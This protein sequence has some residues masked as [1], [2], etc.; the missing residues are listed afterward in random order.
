MAGLAAGDVPKLKLAW[1]FGIPGSLRAY[2]QPTVAGGRVFIG[3]G[4]RKIF[5]LDAARAA[6][7]GCLTR[8]T[9]VR[10]A[11]TIG[12]AGQRW[13]ALFGDQSGQAYAV[14]ARSG[15]LIWKTRVESYPGALITGA[16]ALYEGRLYVP[17]SSGEEIL[18]AMPG[19]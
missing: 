5:S 8:T 3:T 16:P 4:T 12:R 9:G 1:A 10:T 7:F 6:W 18:G 19:L 14:D 13:A 17:V 11:I 2:G 15:E